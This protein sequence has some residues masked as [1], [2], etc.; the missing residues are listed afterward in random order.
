MTMKPKPENLLPSQHKFGPGVRLTVADQNF[1]QRQE[2]AQRAAIA[3]AL[4]VGNRKVEPQTSQ[5]QNIIK[6]LTEDSIKAYGIT[7]GVWTPMMY[8]WI[9]TLVARKEALE[10]VKSTI[11]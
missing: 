2:V 3:V 5:I 11:H 4:F 1:T 7:R 6:Y 8:D 10:A 9:A